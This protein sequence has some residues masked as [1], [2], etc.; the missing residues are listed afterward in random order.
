ME[1]RRVK[2]TCTVE[3]CDRPLLAVG[4]CAGH[5]RR[6]KL[7]QPIDE[8]LKSKRANWRRPCSVPACDDPRYGDGL[9]RGHYRRQ[10]RTGD[11]Q[12]DKPF[13]GTARTI[14][15]EWRPEVG[16]L[17]VWHDE[18]RHLVRFS[19][20]DY[21]LL[22]MVPWSIEKYGYVVHNEE[23]M[24]RMVMG[25]EFKDG[26]QVDHRN[27][28]RTDN[29]RENLRLATARRNTQNQL[30]VNHRG[31][32]KY[33]GVYWADHINKWVARITVNYKNI[34]LGVYSDEDEAGAAVMRY[35]EQHGIW[36]GYGPTSPA[37]G[38][39]A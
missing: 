21:D 3:V 16:E 5:Y 14:T 34:H 25:L 4:L 8:P 22:V 35:R 39:P 15:R 28:V 7:G 38:E 36:P 2:R 10:W 6:L 32:S 1:G 9:C 29:R 30:I 11:V 18:E 26:R 12:A 19:P 17:I 20:E 31:T 33:R 27:G 13:K 37:E 24:H 23:R